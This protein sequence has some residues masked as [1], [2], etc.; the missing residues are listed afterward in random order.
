MIE[1]ERQADGRLR[2]WRDRGSPASWRRVCVLPQRRGTVDA[3]AS[4]EHGNAHAGLGQALGQQRAGDAGAHDHNV[5]LISVIERPRRWA[6]PPNLPGRCW[7]VA[8]EGQR[9]PDERIVQRRHDRACRRGQHAGVPC[10]GD[11]PLPTLRCRGRPRHVAAPAKAGAW[12][13]SAS[14]CHKASAKPR[15]KADAGNPVSLADSARNA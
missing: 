3:R 6:A 4:F 10:G 11:F 8:C 2:V 13:A 15:S 12:P 14:A 9:L 5:G 7:G 1:V